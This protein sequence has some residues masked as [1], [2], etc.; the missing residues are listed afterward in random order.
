MA[1]LHEQFFP[2]WRSPAVQL[3][4]EMTKKSIQTYLRAPYTPSWR[5]A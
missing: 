1:W 2:C 4:V 5:D 3:T